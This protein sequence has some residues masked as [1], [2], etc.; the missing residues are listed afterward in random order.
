L[1]GRHNEGLNVVDDYGWEPNPY[2]KEF[3]AVI[4]EPMPEGIGHGH[5]V[6]VA[7]YKI[8]YSDDS[9][10]LPRFTLLREKAIRFVLTGAPK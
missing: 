6:P 2:V 7:L 3:D 8:G 10:R 4:D 1:T 9:S 5:A